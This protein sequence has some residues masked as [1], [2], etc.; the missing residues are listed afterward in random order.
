MSRKPSASHGDEAEVVFEGLTADA[1]V[2]YSGEWI[3]FMDGRILAHGRRL[4][5][6]LS[7]VKAGGLPQGVRYLPVPSSTGV[8]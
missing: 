2:N 3:A 5:D 1:L 6:V 7:A 4:K 8:Y